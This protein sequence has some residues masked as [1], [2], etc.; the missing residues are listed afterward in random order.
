MEADMNSGKSYKSDQAKLNYE[1][2]TLFCIHPSVRIHF[3]WRRLII[4]K[5]DTTV[6][7]R[8]QTTKFRSWPGLRRAHLINV[9]SQVLVEK[10]L[11]NQKKFLLALSNLFN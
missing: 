8:G 7:T 5:N 9:L 1:K 11:F 3:Y 4:A 2:A 10:F 6:R